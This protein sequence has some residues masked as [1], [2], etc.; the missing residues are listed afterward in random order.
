MKKPYNIQLRVDAYNKMITGR[1]N[2]IRLTKKGYT[3]TLFK[4]SV[5][6]GRL[7][8]I[9]NGVYTLYKGLHK[10]KSNILLEAQNMP[11]LLY[12]L[13]VHFKDPKMALEEKEKTEYNKWAKVIWDAKESDIKVIRSL[14]KPE[15][16]PEERQALLESMKALLPPKP[17]Q[18]EKWE[19]KDLGEKTFEIVQEDGINKIEGT[20]F[21]ISQIL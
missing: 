4:R 8:E 18:V 15:K 6:N 11:A 2:K 16:T 19:P 3:S 7:F 10:D 5:A 20:N 13:Y 1:E 12:Y 17:E 21:V 9:E 14:K